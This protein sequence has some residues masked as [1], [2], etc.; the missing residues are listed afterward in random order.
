MKKLAL[1]V[2]IVSLASVALAAQAAAKTIRV[3]ADFQSIMVA[4]S[5]GSP[6]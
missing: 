6:R 3:P 1:I 2:L 4:G 5:E